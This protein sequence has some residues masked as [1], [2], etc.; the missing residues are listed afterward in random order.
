MDRN[1]QTIDFFYRAATFADAAFN[2]TVKK[3]EENNHGSKFAVASTL[4][5]PC[6]VLH[7]PLTAGTS[8]KG[9]RDVEDRS[10]KESGFVMKAAV[11]VLKDTKVGWSNHPKEMKIVVT[12]VAGPPAKPDPKKE[13]FKDRCSQSPPDALLSGQL[14]REQNAGLIVLIYDN[15]SSFDSWVE[16]TEQMGIPAIV[17]KLTSDQSQLP[18]LVQLAVSDL[19]CLAPEPTTTT[20]TIGTSTA[21]TSAIEVG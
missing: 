3:I 20:T 21:E 11:M 2:N 17:K 13:T 7:I 19:L 1:D 18:L 14:I 12:I 15:D 10:L 9:W 4:T 5:D 6:Y 16:Y 8:V